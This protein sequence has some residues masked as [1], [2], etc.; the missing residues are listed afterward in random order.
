M[1]D[2]RFIVT[3]FEGLPISQDE[4]RIIR[5]PLTTWYVQ[6]T[7][8]NYKV[9]A[10]FDGVHQPHRQH[11]AQHRRAAER[12]CARLNEWWKTELARG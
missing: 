12:E 11:L 4:R 3:E 5:H 7:L 8:Y 9:V 6:D 10:T 1:S 2:P